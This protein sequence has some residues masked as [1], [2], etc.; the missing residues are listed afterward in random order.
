MSSVLPDVILSYLDC[1][2]GSARRAAIIAFLA[3]GWHLAL[4]D[5]P[6]FA[7]KTYARPDGQDTG[8]VS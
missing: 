4:F 1:D 6:L 2:S 8:C 5:V 3:Q 7:G